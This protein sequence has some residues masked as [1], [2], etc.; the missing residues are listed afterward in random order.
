MT[1][2]Q[3]FRVNGP[4]NIHSNSLAL[5]TRE[6]HLPLFLTLTRNRAAKA[7]YNRA[8]GERVEGTIE[9]IQG[10]ESSEA[11]NRVGMDIIVT[12]MYKPQIRV[13]YFDQFTLFVKFWNDIQN[14]WCWNCRFHCTWVGYIPW[15]QDIDIK[16]RPSLL[17]PVWWVDEIH[18]PAKVSIQLNSI[19]KAVSITVPGYHASVALLLYRIPLSIM[20]CLYFCFRKWNLPS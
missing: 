11:G 12:G 9:L 5:V 14:F 6:A 20:R 17:V 7:K 13:W 8:I 1:S 15:T 18:S 3:K 2:T 4:V 19:T 10:F 16:D